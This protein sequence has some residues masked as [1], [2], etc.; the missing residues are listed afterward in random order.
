MDLATLRQ[1]KRDLENWE[2]AKSRTESMLPDPSPKA[3]EARSEQAPESSVIHSKG[4]EHNHSEKAEEIP[5]SSRV[6][7]ARGEPSAVYN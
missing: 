5:P 7:N 3:A 6:E 4:D 1:Y 2:Q